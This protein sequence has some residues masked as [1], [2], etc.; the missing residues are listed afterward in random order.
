[1]AKKLEIIVFVLFWAIFLLEWRKGYFA[2]FK[3]YLKNVQFNFYFRL[4]LLF[5]ALTVCLML[6]DAPLLQEV[7]AIQRPIFKSVLNLGAWLGKKCNLWA[8]VM[9]GYFLVLLFKNEKISRIIFGALLSMGLTVNVSFII[10]HVL[11]RARPFNN[12]G[13]F[14]FFNLDGLLQDKNALQSFPS[15]DV[16]VVAGVACFLFYT[17]KNSFLRY[18]LLIFPLA[19]ALSRVWLNRHWPSDAI[20]SIGLGFISGLFIWRYEQHL[21]NLP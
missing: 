20:F 7:Q 3:S 17:V 5:A 9:V 11:M 15:G 10:K 21:R 14:S 4:F 19:T 1:M 16:A 12:L 6:V 18:A 2:Q 13:P 8:V